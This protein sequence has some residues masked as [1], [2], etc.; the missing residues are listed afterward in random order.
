M[1]RTNVFLC[2]LALVATISGAARAE[3]DV[4]TVVATVNGEDITMGHMVIGYASLPAQYREMP[5]ELL[6]D[7]ILDQLIQQTLL[8]QSFDQTDPKRVTLSLENERRSLLAGEMIETILKDAATEDQVQAAYTQNFVEGAGGEEFNASHILV[9]SKADAEEIIADLNAGEDFAALARDRSTGPSGPNGG[10]LGWMGRGL[11]VPEFESA[12]DLLQPGEIS[13]PVQTEF[14]W[15]VI[16]MNDRRKTEAPELGEVRDQIV[17]QLRREAVES[18]VEDLRKMAT[19]DRP[20]IPG[21]DRNVVTD[22]DLL[23]E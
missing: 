12:M 19:I 11:T 17:N 22:L 8:K 20:D 21:L 10:D 3:T 4:D 6:Y 9:E 5:I 13:P 1:P 2:A 15:H 14:G 18:S 7:A 23:G 16:K